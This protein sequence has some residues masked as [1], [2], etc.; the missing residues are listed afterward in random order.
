MPEPRAGHS[1]VLCDESILTFGGIKTVNYKDNLSSVLSYD[2]KNNEC[3]QLQQLGILYGACA[4][5]SAQSL[6]R[7][8]EIQYG[9]V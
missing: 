4:K 6:G 5:F 1:T 9:R 2:I 7:G 8:S 3:Q